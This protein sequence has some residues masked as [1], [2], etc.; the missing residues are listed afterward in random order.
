[1]K[2][3]VIY[4]YTDTV[5]GCSNKDTLSTTVNA[6]PI[7]QLS[8][9]DTLYCTSDAPVSLIGSPAGG[10]FSGAG[11]AVSGS[12]FNPGGTGITTGGK[13]SIVY[14]YTDANKCSNTDTVTIGI[15]PQ[16]VVKIM[17]TQLAYCKNDPAD[18]ISGYPRGGILS[19]S[20]GQYSSILSLK[21]TG[22]FSPRLQNSADSSEPGFFLYTYKDVASGCSNTVQD[23]YTIYRV[24]KVTFSPTAICHS[25][26]A[27]PLM[28]TAFPSGGAFSYSGPGITTSPIFDPSQTGNG[29][30]QIVCVYDVNGCSGTYIDTVHVEDRNSGLHV[31]SDAGMSSLRTDFCSNEGTLII[32]D[33]AGSGLYS[34]STTGIFNSLGNG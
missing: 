30:F 31:V 24:P 15:R 17:G 29:I 28:A 21:D 14:S 25:A 3:S 11:S 2:H 34:Y 18:T 20:G 13:Y 27:A 1:G 33:S 26:S 32:A 7:V 6:L 9:L 22:V 12:T 10:T 4:S 23:N 16:P 8:G 19:V 5:T